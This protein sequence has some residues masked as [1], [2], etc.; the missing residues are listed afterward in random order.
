[1]A[2]RDRL[3]PEAPPSEAGQRRARPGRTGARR[4]GVGAA[5]PGAGARVGL[6]PERAAAAGGPPVQ[7]S[8]G[9]RWVGALLEAGPVDGLREELSWL[10]GDLGGVR[11]AD[12]LGEQLRR[13]L[14]AHPEIDA[15]AAADVLRVLDRERT[16]ALGAVTGELVGPRCLALL[17]T[18]VTLAA[19][20]PMRPE[21]DGPAASVLPP[22]VVTSWRR[23][24]RHVRQLDD[25]PADEALHRTRIL[26]KRVRYAA[27]AVRPAAPKQ[28]A[29]FARHAAAIQ[30]VLD[31]QH[32]SWWPA[33]GWRPTPRRCGER[34]RPPPA[35][36]PRPSPTTPW[37]RPRAGTATTNGSRPGPAGSSRPAD[38]S[39]GLPGTSVLRRKSLETWSCCVVATIRRPVLQT[40]AGRTGE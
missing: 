28:A 6:R 1:M 31:D 35:D 22:L 11:D 20:P 34:R 27:E 40:A 24:R 39:T 2:Q 36:W 21:A 5:S 4:E 9:R 32:D 16:A 18:L 17:D 14:A 15:D 19:D 23:L 12:V 37:P 33:S 30:T 8:H 7:G 29:Y 25:P 13:R 26:A 38:A 10:G 3:D